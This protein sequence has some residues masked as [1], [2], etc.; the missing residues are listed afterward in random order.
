VEATTLSDV[1]LIRPAVHEDAR[2]YFLETWQQDRYRAAGLPETFFQDNESGS[3]R[4]TLRGLHYQLTQPQGKLVRVT[5]GEVF[6]VAVD[7][8]RSSSDFGRWFGTLLSGANR[9]Q[10]WIPPGFAHGF[11]VLSERAIVAYK[12]TTAYSAAGERVIRWDDSQ[13]AIDWPLPL[14]AAPLLSTRDANAC[15]LSMAELFP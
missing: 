1:L 10:I 8:R 12:C 7:L 13:L 4:H 5:E 3:R 2:G 9:C 14:H 11:L 6:D 15:P